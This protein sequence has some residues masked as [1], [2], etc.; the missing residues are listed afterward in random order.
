MQ[1][2]LQCSLSDTEDLGGLDT[3]ETL[4]VPQ[5]EDLLILRAKVTHRPS[6]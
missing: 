3:G 5:D 4:D 6:K 1:S 2:A